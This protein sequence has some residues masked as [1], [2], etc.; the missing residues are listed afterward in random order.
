MAKLDVKRLTRFKSQPSTQ[1]EIRYN[2]PSCGDL[3]GRLWA[4]FRK[5][6]WTCFKCGESGTILPR[7][8]VDVM[9]EEPAFRGETVRQFDWKTYPDIRGTG[10]AYLDSHNIPIDYAWKCGVRSG[11]GD[12]SGRLVIPVKYNTRQGIRTVFRVAHAASD[13]TVPKELQAGDR[14]P[15][16][17]LWDMSSGPI[18][19]S[20]PN[21]MREREQYQHYTAVVVEGAADALR[22][23]SVVKTN[24]KLTRC[25]AIV[26]LWGKHLPEET[27][28]DL[29]ATFKHFYVML[30]REDGL[31]KFGENVASMRIQQKLAAIAEG[32]VTRHVWG[33]SRKKAEMDHGAKDPADLTTD[34]VDKIMHKALR[35]TGGG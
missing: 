3:A 28:F 1:H 16:I 22:L 13:T 27:A 2:C 20:S 30:D 12:A 24:S 14:K 29:A 7:D 8:V 11:K 25:I 15:W 6:V 5:G 32:V 35:A 21:L 17:L 34:Q 31:N 18:I 33:Q 23:A 26:C 4:N 10:V 9:G 19:A